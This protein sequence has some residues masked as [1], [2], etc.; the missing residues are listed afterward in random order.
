M[1]NLQEHLDKAQHNFDFLDSFDSNQRGNYRGWIVTVYFY[2]ALHYVDA[3][4][5]NKGYKE[6]NTHEERKNHIVIFQSDLK[7]S[8]YRKY[9]QLEDDSRNAR[10]STKQ[11]TRKDVDEVRQKFFQPIKQRIEN[12]LGI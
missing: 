7:P 5:A 4:L 8:I 11:F 2:T 12:L 1:P 6:F 9:R 3:Y 10:Y